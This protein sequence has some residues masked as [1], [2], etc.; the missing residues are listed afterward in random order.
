[1]ATHLSLRVGQDGVALLFDSDGKE[2]EL[3]LTADETHI[4][5]VHLLSALREVDA[6]QSI[7][8]HMRS[9]LLSVSVSNIDIGST[10]NGDLLLSFVPQNLP[11]LHFSMSDATAAGLRQGILNL[12][13]IPKD[14]RSG[15]AAH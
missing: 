9:P 10:D 2:T 8:T 6:R 14:A 7:P 15:G 12:L 5:I 3:H 1:M 13:K 4:L 11:P